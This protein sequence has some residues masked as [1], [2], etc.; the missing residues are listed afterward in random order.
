[1]SLIGD[2]VDRLIE[3]TRRREE[4]GRTVYQTFV[5]PLLAD[6]DVLHRDYLSTFRKYRDAVAT[7]KHVDERL[8]DEIATDSLFSKDL[9]S[10]VRLF[11]DDAIDERILPLSTAVRQY[12]RLATRNPVHEWT[13]TWLMYR[14]SAH[15]DVKSPFPSHASDDLDWQV[16][17]ELE[18][19]ERLMN[20]N[21]GRRYIYGGLRELA[22]TEEIGSELRVRLAIRLIECVASELQARHAVVARAHEQVRSALLIPP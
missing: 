20:G 1:M 5:A 17:D 14:E 21:A 15:P 12:L 8:L 7:T 22:D 16:R 6:L 2:V 13:V 10:K 11:R 19:A 4:V 3:I 9:R 18:S